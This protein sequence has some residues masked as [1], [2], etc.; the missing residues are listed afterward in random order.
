M[1]QFTFVNKGYLLIYQTYL[2]N[3]SI[4]QGVAHIIPSYIWK[5]KVCANHLIYIIYVIGQHNFGTD[6]YLLAFAKAKAITP[7]KASRRRFCSGEKEGSNPSFI[8]QITPKAL[9]LVFNGT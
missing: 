3:H 7:A 1:S 9:S 6:T 4:N 8:R 2:A 5:H